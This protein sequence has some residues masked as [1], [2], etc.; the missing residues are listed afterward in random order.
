M[1][2]RLN[3]LFGLKC[4][5]NRPQWVCKHS[6]AKITD[7]LNKRYVCMICNPKSGRVKICPQPLYLSILREHTLTKNMSPDTTS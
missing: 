2:L 6:E 3:P 1:D 7:Y 5:E 4:E